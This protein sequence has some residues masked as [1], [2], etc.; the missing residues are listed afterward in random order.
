MTQV[1]SNPKAVSQLFEHHAE[2]IGALLFH[3]VTGSPIE[4]PAGVSSM[5]L[6]ASLLN[7]HLYDPEVVLVWNN[8]FQPHHL[9]IWAPYI[10]AS[11]YRVAIVC[12]SMPQAAKV[13]ESLPNTPV[14]A[15]DQNILAYQQLP[16]AP[17]LKVFLYPDNERMNEHTVHNYPRHMHVH[18]GHG[19]SD[20][21]TSANRFGALY[22]HVFLADRVALERYRRAGIEIP[23]HHFLPIGAPASPGVRFDP[24]AAV[25]PNVL[26]APTWE[27]TSSSKNFSSLPDVLPA[28]ADFAAG[29]PGQLACRPHAYLGGRDP[30]YKGWA[31]ELARWPAPQSQKAAQFNASDVLLC[32]VSGIL[33]EYLFTGKPVIVPAASDNAWLMAYLEQARLLD[34]VYRWPFDQVS[35][36]DFLGRIAADP[37][38][39][40]R[41]KRRDDLIAGAKDF[42]EASA[43]F[44][45]ALDSVI[46]NHFWRS[47]RSGFTAPVVPLAQG[48]EPWATLSAQIRSGAVTLAA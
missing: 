7:I 29:N 44:D 2:T 25:G 37:L 20:K 18:I 3:P 6:S 32:D 34:F 1:V 14:W 5:A 8:Q 23:D 38:R 33:S 9:A 19:D 16:V 12:R 41:L 35:L 26:Y 27:G 36:R 45:R 39:A 30:A 17:S 48:D 42:D 4:F 22:D 47:R 10:R 11:R 21:S 15:L 40:Q 24:A 13:R 43:N 46:L 31:A 28:L